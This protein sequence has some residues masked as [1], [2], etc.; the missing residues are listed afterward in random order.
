[1]GYVGTDS[2]LVLPDNYRGRS[3]EV[4]NAN[5]SDLGGGA[6]EY[7]RGIDSI[8]I[9]NGIEDLSG[10]VFYGCDVKH[11][12][13]SATVEELDVDWCDLES[14]TVDAGNPTYKTIDGLLYKNEEYC[15]LTLVHYPML[16]SDVTDYTL[17]YAA[18]NIRLRE[19]PTTLNSFTIP[20]SVTRIETLLWDGTCTVYYAGTVEQWE[21]MDGYFDVS[22][23]VHCTN[24]DWSVQK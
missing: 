5:N 1:M 16:K 17:P 14:I 21:G 23:T 2:N 12:H 15:G 19:L 8:T 10:N 3:Y 9:P 6:L 20:T 7:L 22:G 13:L 24:G 11:L 18:K 4:L